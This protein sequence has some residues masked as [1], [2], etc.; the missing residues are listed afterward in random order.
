MQQDLEKLFQSRNRW[1]HFRYDSLIKPEPIL[2]WLGSTIYMYSVETEELGHS[3]DHIHVVCNYKTD[4]TT[5][6]LNN[7]LVKLLGKDVNKGTSTIRTTQI[8][9]MTYIC[10]L[11]D[12]MVHVGLTNEFLATVKLHSW[13]K[14]NKTKYSAERFDIEHRFYSYT[15]TFEELA[16]AIWEL[17]DKYLIDQSDNA[18]KSYLRKHY[19][20]RHKDRGKMRASNLAG[21]VERE[22]YPDN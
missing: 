8:Q 3:K 7:H 4:H 6:T 16:V 11:Y 5:R 20:H 2:T 1:V 9:S 21:I 22:I 13:E 12:T 17:N 10:K 18:F 15:L 14:M 19:L